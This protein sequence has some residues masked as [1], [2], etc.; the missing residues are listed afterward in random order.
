MEKK[1]GTPRNAEHAIG[2]I[3]EDGISYLNLEPQGSWD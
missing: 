3:M 2:A 1:H